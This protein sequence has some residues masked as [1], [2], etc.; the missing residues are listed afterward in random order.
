V[1]DN[2]SPQEGVTTKPSLPATAARYAA[3]VLAAIIGSAAFR[4]L[5]HRILAMPQDEQLRGPIILAFVLGLFWFA[6]ASLVLARSSSTGV[7][8]PQWLNPSPT[9]TRTVLRTITLALV[10]ACVIAVTAWVGLYL[11]DEIFESRSLPWIA[12]LITMQTYGFE[13]ASQMFPCHAEGSDTGCEASKWIPTFLMANGLAYF[14]LVLIGLLS[15]QHSDAVRKAA[16]AG[17]GLFARWCAVIV[18]AGLVALQVMHGLNLDTNDSLY[19]HPGIGHWHFGAW[20]QVSDITGTLISLAGLALP[21]WLYRAIRRTNG[22]PE[23]RTRLAAATSLA[24]TLL[25][26]LMLGDVY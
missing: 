23:S 24:A 22:V 8:F 17:A 1:S 16:R 6:L 2:A 26:A 3:I 4:L 25:V 15:S 14:P 19:P 7:G 20:E 13:K 5:L 11:N 18:T 21:F 12:P 10:V 9:G